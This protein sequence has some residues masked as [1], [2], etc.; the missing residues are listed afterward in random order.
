MQPQTFYYVSVRSRSAWAVL[1]VLLSVGQTKAGLRTAQVFLT[2]LGSLSDSSTNGIVG[3]Q[4]EYPPLPVSP[5]PD[6]TS[7]AS[8]GASDGLSGDGH[9]QMNAKPGLGNASWL[10][11]SQSTTTFDVVI[12]PLP[13]NG[14]PAS[15]V[16]ASLNLNLRGLL[17]PQMDLIEGIFIGG[18]KANANVHLDVT[19]NGVHLVGDYSES[20]SGSGCSVTCPPGNFAKT[21]SSNVSGL[22]A[23]YGYVNNVNGSNLDFSPGPITV[24]VGTPFPVSLGLSMQSAAGYEVGGTGFPG[25]N[26]V[27]DAYSNYQFSVQLTAFGLPDGY[28]AN[29]SDGHIV[30]NQSG[31]VLGDYNGNGAVDAADYVYWR[32]ND[33]TQAGYDTWRAHFGQSIP[34]AG[35]GAGA[36]ANAAVPEPA[37]IVM[38]TFAAAGWCVRRG[39]TA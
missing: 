7:S 3:V 20:V 18:A 12:S 36:S 32:K 25:P 23:S 1:V 10:A 39:R 16:P 29:S 15:S 24:P 38:L 26:F 4:M 34:G 13:S 37:T 21:F 22:L 35:S 28:T 33:G 2:Q 17:L 19:V 5:P 8:A 6:V 30:D 9:V 14:S 31:R 27:G 11:Q